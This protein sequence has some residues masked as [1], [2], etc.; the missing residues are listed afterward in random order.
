MG[1]QDTGEQ[2][3]GEQDTRG[4]DMH[5]QD[6]GEPTSRGSDGLGWTN[7][8]KEEKSSAEPGRPSFIQSEFIEHFLCPWGWEL[9]LGRSRNGIPLMQLTDSWG[10]PLCSWPWGCADDSPAPEKQGDKVG[11][12]PG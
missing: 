9:L 1:E 2:H 10:A 8:R 12:H 7:R 3:T 5:G 6:T 11:T 4:Q